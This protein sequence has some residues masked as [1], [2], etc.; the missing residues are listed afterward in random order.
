MAKGGPHASLNSQLG[1]H[2]SKG[3]SGKGGSQ[4][5]DMPSSRTLAQNSN[6]VGDCSGSSGD[7]YKHV[8]GRGPD[9]DNSQNS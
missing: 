2:N 6:S 4:K 7:A 5:S 8:K 1:N 3:N 9:G